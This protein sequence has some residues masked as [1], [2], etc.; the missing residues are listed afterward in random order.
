M[1]P[2]LRLVLAIAFTLAVLSCRKA[3]DPFFDNPEDQWVALTES[4]TTAEVF[5][6][7]EKSMRRTHPANARLA[8][9]LGPRGEEVV[10]LWIEDMRDGGG[11]YEAYHYNP[12]IYSLYK[13]SGYLV[14]RDRNR[15]LAARDIIAERMGDDIETA[16]RQLRSSCAG[17]LGAAP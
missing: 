13:Y 8:E 7:Y 11:L 9:A 17:A 10:D 16:S 1:S 15:I 2:K 12:I 5:S 6:L 3:D 14:C 4:M